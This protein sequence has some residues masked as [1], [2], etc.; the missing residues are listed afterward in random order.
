LLGLKAE[1]G[2]FAGDVDLQENPRAHSFLGGNAVHVSGNL[3]GINAVEELKKRQ[4]LSDLV[5]LQMANEVPLGPTAHE[6][7]FG[8]CLLDPTFPEN[9]LPFP[10]Q[11]FD[12]FRG[13]RF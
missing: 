12:G 6:R 8:F 9:G 1:L 2:R 11:R 3:Q 13:L 5:P 10:Q 4:G 7:D